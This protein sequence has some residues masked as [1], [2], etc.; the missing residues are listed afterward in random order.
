[1]S[2]ADYLSKKYLTADAPAEKKSK[3]RKRKAAA[4]AEASGGL[5][6]ADDDITGWNNGP[7]AQDDEDAPMMVTDTNSAEFRKKAS[8]GWKTVGAAAPSSADQ[9]AAD[10]IIA[11]A[12]A[13]NAAHGAAT[14]DDGPM[15]IDNNNADDDEGDDGTPAM[16]SGAKAG[17]QTAA[18]VAAAL[19]KRQRA[20]RR[21][22]EQAMREAGGTA[23]ETIYRDASGRIINVAMKRAEARRAA[24]EEEARKRREEEEAKGDVQQAEK[25]A[26]MQRLKEAKYLT[27][28]RGADDAEINEEMREKERW[29]DPA[30]AFLSKKKEGKSRT[31]RPLYKGA[32]EPNRE[33]FK[34]RNAR[35]NRANLEYAWQMDE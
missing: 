26:R 11:S 23:A 29:S 30:L 25:K 31:G 22:M 15:I 35:Q 2:L 28:A 12:A 10:A 5:I 4:A 16:D 8:S 3:K 33:W 20:E 7:Q 1:M 13:E 17:L 19:E 14:G 18:Q 6:I 32:F 9:A 27:V 21:H 24:E 34:S